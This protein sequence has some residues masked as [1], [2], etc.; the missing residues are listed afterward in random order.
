[1]LITEGADSSCLHDQGG[2][3]KWFSDPSHGERSQDVTV[4]CDE[5][6]SRH[7]GGLLLSNDGLMMIVANVLN[8][9]VQSVYNVLGR[10]ASWAAVS[11]DIPGWEIGGLP[12]GADLC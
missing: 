3:G 1:M 12:L 6:V 11:P 8:Q 5:D 4:T 2:L 10:F 9:R 7:V